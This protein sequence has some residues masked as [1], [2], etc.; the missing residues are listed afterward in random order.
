MPTDEATGNIEP[1]H[2]GDPTQVGRFRLLG[3]LGAGIVYLAAGQDPLSRRG[4]LNP[5]PSDYKSG[6]LPVAPR[7]RYPGRPPNR[8]SGRYEWY[9]QPT[10]AHREYRQPP[11]Q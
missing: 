8:R 4:D 11:P 2:N 10:P 1:P 5:Q 3:R 9:R 7:R 6:A